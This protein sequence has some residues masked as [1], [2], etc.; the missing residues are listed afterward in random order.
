MTSTAP[1]DS[2]GSGSDR[3]RER[4]VARQPIQ[5]CTTERVPRARNTAAAA[6]RQPVASGKESASSAKAAAYIASA[7]RS[8]ARN[9]RSLARLKRG[10]G[11]SPSP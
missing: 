1:V 4:S 11:S 3:R 8:Q 9:V 6:I 5:A 2:P 10:S 7:V